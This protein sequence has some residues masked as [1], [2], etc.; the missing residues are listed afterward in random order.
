MKHSA[1]QNETQD[2]TQDQNTW[3]IKEIIRMQGFRVLCLIN[4]TPY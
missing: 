3:L 4:R 1:N 2:E